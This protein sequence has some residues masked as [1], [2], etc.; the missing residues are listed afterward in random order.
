MHNLR[1]NC[2]FF[3]E[4]RSKMDEL[5]IG[6]VSIIFRGTQDLYYYYAD[7]SNGTIERSMRAILFLWHLF[8][9]N[10]HSICVNGPCYKHKIFLSL[11]NNRIKNNDFGSILLK[12]MLK[13][14]LVVILLGIIS[15]WDHVKVEALFWLSFSFFYLLNPRNESTTFSGI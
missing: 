13:Y 9:L 11:S 6:G 1:I 12:H 4:K 10:R 3:R 5:C 8:P 2:F 7:L 15:R 14:L